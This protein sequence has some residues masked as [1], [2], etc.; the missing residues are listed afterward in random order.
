MSYNLAEKSYV[1]T[2]ST[3]GNVNLTYQQV[4][5]LITTTV[6][7]IESLSG[8]NILCIDCDIGHR[9]DTAEIKY[10]F[11][12]DSSETVVASGIDFYYKNDEADV[13]TSLVTNIDSHYYYST[14]PGL[15]APRY[16]RLIHTISGTSISGT[17]NGFEI[18]NN[19]SIVDFGADGNLIQ[20]NIITTIADGD[21]IETIPVYNDGVVTSTAYI[22]IEPQE[23]DID[24]GVFI[25]NSSGGPWI[26]P[27]DPDEMFVSASVL[28]QGNYI[29]N[30]QNLSGE[31]S[32]INTTLSGMYRS[33]IAYISYTPFNYLYLNQ[34][35]V[36][37]TNAEVS[38]D[39]DDPIPTMEVRG[40]NTKPLDF[41]Q[42][43]EMTFRSQSLVIWIRYKDSYTEDELFYFESGDLSGQIIAVYDDKS[44]RIYKQYL[45]ISPKNK[46]DFAF[47]AHYWPLDATTNDVLSSEQSQYL[48]IGRYIN[49]ST[50][51]AKLI[52]T[53]GGF[54]SH[55]AVT[56]LRFVGLDK[57]NGVWCYFYYKK[58]TDSRPY[59]E[60]ISDGYHLMYYDNSFSRTIHVEDANTDF[61]HRLSLDYENDHIW[62]ESIS[63]NSVIKL[64]NTNTV[65]ASYSSE[66][67]GLNGIAALSDGGCWFANDTR[68]MRLDTN[69]NK[70]D[71]V[72]TNIVNIIDIE[73]DGDD[74]LWIANTEGIRRIFTDGREHFFV[75]LITVD[76][77]KAT[78]LGLWVQ[79][80]DATI[81][82]IK[83]DLQGIYKTLDNYRG[84]VGPMDIEVG[85]TYNGELFPVSHDTY[86]N[87]LEWNKVGIEGYML[88]EYY[89]HQVR[90][91]LWPGEGVA[92]KVR[93]LYA[94]KNVM[95]KDIEPSNSKDVYLKVSVNDVPRGQSYDS[96]LRVGWSLP[97]A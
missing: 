21:Q 1:G 14:V 34:T 70:V 6:G 76:T 65:L 4:N 84:M 30:T 64:D 24:N 68:L 59:N 82:Y 36:T 92:P 50:S 38:V 42:F 62:Y 74:A 52:G 37:G 49:G 9:V 77:I 54:Y 22:S 81:S 95:L 61:V 87:N 31:L 29:A 18:L 80:T 40:S 25:S 58:N 79:C 20:K 96:N 39:I 67:D 10:Y 41:A 66:I 43:R 63:S 57:N 94:V 71:E 89:Y 88:P 27:L 19:D 44:K 5:T 23:T 78:D 7:D 73:I 90:L 13:Y 55:R 35:T 16:V 53:D 45:D 17:V 11:T 56:D 47:I 85:G 91:T 60:W 93:N 32:L 75:P 15:G 2:N 46:D 86:W 69:G 12:S 51:Y 8:D 28:D 97:L 72:E 26:S 83:R 33:R 3:L 48:F